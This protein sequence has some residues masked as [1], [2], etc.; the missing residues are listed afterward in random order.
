[1]FVCGETNEKQEAYE[2]EDFDYD[3]EQET[4][5]YWNKDPNDQGYHE[6]LETKPDDEDSDESEGE[7]DAETR[8]GIRVQNITDELARRFDLDEREGVIISE[9]ERGS[10]ASREGLRRGDIILEVNHGIVPIVVGS[11]S[12]SGTVA[13]RIRHDKGEN[14]DD[15]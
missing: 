14:Q 7:E 10:V 3:G 5:G 13:Y 1:M 4:Q 11:H 12:A 6:G 15:Y 9:I 2:G 8:V